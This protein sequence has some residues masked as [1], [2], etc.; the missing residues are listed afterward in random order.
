MVDHFEWDLLVTLDQ[1]VGEGKGPICLYDHHPLADID[2]GSLFAHFASKGHDPLALPAHDRAIARAREG[3]CGLGHIHEH[4]VA[5]GLLTI[6]IALGRRIGVE[7]IIAFAE[8]H[9]VKGKCPR[10]GREFAAIFGAVY[11]QDHVDP[12]LGE[13]SDVDRRTKGGFWDICKNGWGRLE[14]VLDRRR[15]VRFDQHSREAG[16]RRDPP[17][18][19][20]DRDRDGERNEEES[21]PSRPLA[22]YPRES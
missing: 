4:L 10:V 21:L 2:F 6:Q 17:K 18:D 1:L 14:L 13:T 11:V 9:I 5:L 20:P 16:D 15:T 19:H 3:N 12:R 22:L 8:L 7:H